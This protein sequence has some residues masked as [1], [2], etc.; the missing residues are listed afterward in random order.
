LTLLCE[1]S[2]TRLNLLLKDLV[3]ETYGDKPALQSSKLKK[4]EDKHEISFIITFREKP[5][6]RKST[7]LIPKPNNHFLSASCAFDRRLVKSN[8]THKTALF[9]LM[10]FFSSLQAMDIFK[11]NKR[12]FP[13]IRFYLFFIVQCK[14]KKSCSQ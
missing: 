6:S 1:A 3:M 14:R 7:T 12:I 13:K 9:V 2:K 4:S 11:K 5:I 8:T 10:I